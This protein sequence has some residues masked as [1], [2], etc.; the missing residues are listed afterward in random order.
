MPKQDQSLSERRVRATAVATFAA[1]LLFIPFSVSFAIE[2]VEVSTRTS[3]GFPPGFEGVWI[4][5]CAY[6]IGALGLAVVYL[7]DLFLSP[8][9]P[10]NK[11]LWT[12]LLLTGPI[13][14]AY[15]WIIYMRHDPV[16]PA[17]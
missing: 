8:G 4:A 16:W 7:K 15:Y 12:L 11:V 9:A 3:R 17:A 1:L 13:A 14:M 2:F 5:T 10:S 6:S